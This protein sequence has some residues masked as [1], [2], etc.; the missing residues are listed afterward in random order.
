[1]LVL[2]VALGIYGMVTG[3]HT[4]ARGDGSRVADGPG[5]VRGPQPAPA[6]QPD[7]LP[8]LPNA[9]HS[10]GPEMFARNVATTLF[11]WNTSS[12]FM[13]LDY[14]SV[15]LEVG[16]PSGA[17]Q[18]GLAADLAAY[19]P[20]RAAWLQLRKYATRQHLT[21]RTAF[22]PRSWASAVA[23]ARP[24]QLAPGTLAYTVEG[25]RHRAGVWNDER[26]TSAHAV[27]FTLFI[28][29]APTYESCHLLRLS[30]LDKALR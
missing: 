26:V 13:P 17:E 19:L 30:Q 27:A 25:V 2:L 18:A 10:T 7:E 16:D 9:P 5:A 20:S 8:T 22:V 6:R 21:I 29:C 28:V 23:Q 4:A 24:G 3:P 15:L 1:M 12:G 11:A 14:A